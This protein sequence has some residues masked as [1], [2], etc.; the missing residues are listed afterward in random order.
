MRFIRQSII[1][2]GSVVV[3]HYWQECTN[4]IAECW[5]H[6]LAAKPVIVGLFFL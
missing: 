5:Q 2:A 3:I 6:C 1:N 4:P